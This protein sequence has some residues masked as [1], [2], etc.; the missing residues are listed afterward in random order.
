MGIDDPTFVLSQ[1]YELAF[2]DKMLA[3]SNKK[4]NPFPLFLAFLTVVYFTI[5]LKY[6]LK[7]RFLTDKAPY[8]LTTIITMINAELH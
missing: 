5:L 7:D 4:I 1:V 8:K 3:L 2:F 6:C